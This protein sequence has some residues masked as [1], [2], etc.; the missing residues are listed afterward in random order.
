MLQVRVHRDYSLAARD[1]ETG[2]QR[3]LV[4]EVPREP[5]AADTRIVRSCLFDYG[6]RRVARSVIDQHE[7]RRSHPRAPAARGKAGARRA[8]TR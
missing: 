4:A 5:D 2:H 6:P 8:D 7:L 1:A 3:K